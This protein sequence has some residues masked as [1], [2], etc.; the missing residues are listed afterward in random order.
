MRFEYAMD[1]ENVSFWIYTTEL[2][3][4]FYICTKITSYQI[5]C[6][7]NLVLYNPPIRT[8]LPVGSY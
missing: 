3:L 8:W 6:D 1:F 5:K 4:K 2:A 7:S